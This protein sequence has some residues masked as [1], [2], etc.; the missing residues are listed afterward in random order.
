MFGFMSKL[1]TLRTSLQE[2]NKATFGNIFSKVLEMKDLVQKAETLFDND[3]TPEHRANLHK[4]RAL[5]TQANKNVFDFWKQK[6]NLKWIQEGD[7]NTSFF[8]SVVKGKR[9]QQ[10]ISRIKSS[11][12]L[13][14]E[15]PKD[16]LNEAR[17][18][19]SELFYNQP[20]S[21]MSLFSQNI[22]HLLT[23]EDNISLNQLPTEGEP[24]S[25]MSLFSQNIPHLLTEKDNISLNQLPTE[26]EVRDAV[27]NLDP[28][29]APEP[30][31]FNGEFYRKCWDTIK[32]DVTK[33][34][35][36]FFLGIPIPKAMASSTIILIPKKENLNCLADF[37][38]IC[39]SN[40]MA[41]IISKILS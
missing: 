24:T 29:S 22:P 4:L 6:A 23:E 11:E 30:D 31:G 35:Q 5:Q 2:W 32:V 13:W 41:K 10:K 8:H 19:Y 38:P 12:G 3:P 26:G 15:N 17:Q 20:T 27:W 37:R 16:I 34:A 25:N 21:N 40:F 18:Y 33:A 39:L 36:E 9:I 28:N 14:L 7:C 1:N